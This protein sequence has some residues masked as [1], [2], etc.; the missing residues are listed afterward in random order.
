MITSKQTKMADPTC[1]L[2]SSQPSWSGV[3]SYHTIHFTPYIY[4]QWQK[5]TKRMP[6]IF[7]QANSNSN[8]FYWKYR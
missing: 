3:S 5:L 4:N 1:Y 6:Y 2:Y 8:D 7:L